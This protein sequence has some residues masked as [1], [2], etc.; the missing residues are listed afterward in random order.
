[1]TTRPEPARLDTVRGTTRQIIGLAKSIALK[2]VADPDL[3][4]REG[5]EALEVVDILLSSYQAL[6]RVGEPDSRPQSSI[7]AQFGEAEH[8]DFKYVK[9]ARRILAGLY[10]EKATAS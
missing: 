1:M 7:I 3:T 8:A 10:E 2:A 9:H 5:G 6:I 4:T